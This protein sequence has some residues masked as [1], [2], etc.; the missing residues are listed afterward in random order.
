MGRFR[1]AFAAVTAGLAAVGLCACGPAGSMAGGQGIAKTR[2]RAPA[3]ATRVPDTTVFSR[4]V[5]ALDRVHSFRL[6]ATWFYDDVVPRTLRAE[7]ALPG[8]FRLSIKS[9]GKDANLVVIGATA[10]IR[11]NVPYWAEAV[12]APNAVHVLSAHWVKVPA[13]DVPNLG[14]Y[15]A[16][17]QPQTVGRCVLGSTPGTVTGPYRADIDGQTKLALDL[18]VDGA[19]SGVPGLDILLSA[20]GPPLPLSIS[21]IGPTELSGADPACGQLQ[22]QP[23]PVRDTMLSFSR[24]DA[25]IRITAPNGWI[26]DAGVADAIRASAPK[27][28]P[29]GISERVVQEHEMLGTWVAT[30][31]IIKSHNFADE[32]PGVRFQRLWRI[33]DSCD[34]GSCR[35]DITRTTSAG[36]VTT[37]LVW[38]GDHWTATFVMTIPC[39][40]HTV[41]TQHANWT[42]RVRPGAIAAVEHDRTDSCGPSTSVA[43]WIA[44]PALARPGN[45]SS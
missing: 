22:S 17:A 32:R 25:P 35:P 24:Y 18:Q 4:A 1:T 13:S 29:T 14:A 15:Q 10:Y 16:L 6:D 44:H 23:N 37:W 2:T 21:N 27:S 9:G 19:R 7:F 40:D 3:P 33:S 39:T 31:T 12:S 34:R 5:A 30:G 38:T 28:A 11:G 42:I 45:V 43:Q 20:T 8:R 36:P 41:T 26:S